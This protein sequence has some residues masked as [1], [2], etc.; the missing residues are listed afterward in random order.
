MVADRPR[1]RPRLCG[2]AL[3]RGPALASDLPDVVVTVLGVR[4]SL[5][6]LTRGIFLRMLDDMRFGVRRGR[7]GTAV[8]RVIALLLMIGAAVSGSGIALAQS[9]PP[10]PPAGAPPPP[11]PGAP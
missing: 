7:S 9:T 5:S 1:R 2:R 11:P 8:L 6:R 4:G 3:R 10:P